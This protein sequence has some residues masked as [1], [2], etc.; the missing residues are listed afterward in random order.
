MAPLL[1][2]L[3]SVQL[4]PPSSLREEQKGPAQA[5]SSLIIPS[6]D[7][8]TNV[9]GLTISINDSPS[10]PFLRPATSSFVYDPD[11]DPARLGHAASAFGST[12]GTHLIGTG[13]GGSGASTASYV[14]A[15]T[16]SGSG[17]A[18]F[19]VLAA[20]SSSASSSLSVPHTRQSLGRP[21][22]DP[23][24]FIRAVNC[25]RYIVFRPL[26]RSNQEAAASKY[27]FSLGLQ[28]GIQWRDKKKLTQKKVEREEIVSHGRNAIHIVVE[29]G[30]HGDAPHLGRFSSNGWAKYVNKN[31]PEDRDP[32]GDIPWQQCKDFMEDYYKSVGD[33]SRY[34]AF[35][36]GIVHNDIKL[37]NIH[38]LPDYQYHPTMD[39][40]MP[41]GIDYVDWGRWLDVE[42]GNGP[43]ADRVV[44]TSTNTVCE[45]RAAD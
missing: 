40:S 15:D 26:R 43:E 28:L 13:G 33:L 38:V 2:R 14:G 1:A 44:S 8:W 6:P 30:F 12:A 32:N 34:Y 21:T 11:Q 27:S 16:A 4:R 45:A 18:G 23:A 3:T 42:Q 22:G 36:G 17:D 29:E 35:D 9:S 7:A 31:G 41:Q 10:P 5:Q 20:S 19:I 24:L 39:Y 25:C 37:P